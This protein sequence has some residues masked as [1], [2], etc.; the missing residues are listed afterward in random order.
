MDWLAFIVF[1]VISALN[2]MIPI[3]LPSLG[4]TLT[5]KAGV[6]NIGLEGIML[7]AALVGLFA[8]EVTGSWVMGY[9]I[10]GFLGAFLALLHGVISIYLNGDQIV[11]GIGL[12]VIG[13]GFTPF[14]IIAIWGV[15]G[16]HTLAEEFSVPRIPIVWGSNV[17]TLSPMVPIAVILVVVTHILIR[18]TNIGL[19]I[20]AAGENPEAVEVIGVDVRLLRL[21]VT[22]FG[23]F[24]AGMGG[25]FLSID[26]LKAI[27]NNITSGRGFLAL[28]NVVFARWEPILTLLGGF[29]FGL[30]EALAIRADIL[31]LKGIIPDN[32]IRMIPYIA[33]LIIVAGFVGKARA[34]KSLAEPYKK[35]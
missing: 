32:F 20:R 4:E 28:A 12:N 19:M 1:L 11:S 15:A 13:L 8:A 26:E 10:A 17:I 25:A 7:M 29:I 16:Q 34:P 18:K 9:L 30:F 27:T 6:V 14:M 21:Y 23:G 22:V 31:G 2:Y 5:E 3:L 24:L 35:E 33:T